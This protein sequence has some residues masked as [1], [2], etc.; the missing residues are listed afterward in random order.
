MSQIQKAVHLPTVEPYV[1]ASTDGGYVRTIIKVQTMSI[2]I[3]RKPPLP[4]PGLVPTLGYRNPVVI[5]K[6][7][8]EESLGVAQDPTLV[9]LTHQAV[10]TVWNDCYA[11]LTSATPKQRET[12]FSDAVQVLVY[13]ELD[14]KIKKLRADIQKIEVDHTL[15]AYDPTPSPKDTDEDELLKMIEL[16]TQLQEEPSADD[17]ASFKR[18]LDS[19]RKGI[20]A[21]ITLQEQLIA[22]RDQL[23]ECCKDNWAAFKG[24]AEAASQVVDV[25]L[26]TIES[27]ISAA[28]TKQLRASKLA[29]LL[30]TLSVLGALVLLFMRKSDLEVVIAEKRQGNPGIANEDLLNAVASYYYSELS[31]E[32]P[33]AALDEHVL[34]GMIKAFILQK[35]PE[36]QPKSDSED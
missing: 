35:H 23:N 14:S 5:P 24:P 7:S 15:V 20:Q 19:A 25:F 9:E 1:G 2:T 27:T 36:L 6:V 3:F 32:H 18:A 10:L 16:Q 31:Q 13:K 22:L 29:T 26:P 30:L 12:I 21:K 8:T 28:G 33:T 11:V 34:K 17:S 4:T